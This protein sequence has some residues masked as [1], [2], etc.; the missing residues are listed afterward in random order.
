MSKSKDASVPWQATG[1]KPTMFESI[2]ETFDS[3]AIAFI[4]AFLFRSFE[5]EAFVIPTGSMALTLMGAHKEI[6]CPQCSMPYRVG[7]SE[8]FPEEEN[9]RP[10]RV[11][12][13]ICPNCR[14]RDVYADHPDTFPPTF[15]GDRILVTKFP[16]EFADPKRFDVA[17][18]KNPGE[19]KQNYI[20]RVVGLPQ[21][22]IL[23]YRGDI[24]ARSPEANQF[25][26]ARK[27]PEKIVAIM[28]TVYDNDH[29]L[30]QLIE[31]GWPQRWRQSQ[32]NGE[33]VA[34][35]DATWQTSADM[36][37]FRAVGK[38]PVEAWLRYEHV[39]PDDRAWRILTQRPLTDEDRRTFCKPQL[40]AD[41]CEYNT[42]E[43]ND[44]SALGIHWVSDLAL[45]CELEFTDRADDN[46]EAILEL[47]EGG[48]A[49]QCRIRAATGDVEL[50]IEGVEGYHPTAKAAVVGK[51]PHRLRFA[52]ID[53]HLLLWVGN[54]PIAFDAST[55]FLATNS[56]PVFTIGRDDNNT[57]RMVTQGHK[58]DGD[59]KFPPLEI[60]IPTE[61][62]LRSPVG[63]AA[64][65]VDITASHL[66]LK[67]DLYYVADKG[68]EHLAEYPT[69]PPIRDNVADYRDNAFQAFE[70]PGLTQL[71][72]EWRDADVLRAFM[73]DVKTAPERWS[74]LGAVTF[75]LQADQFFVLGDN[76]PKS[77]DGRLW[78]GQ[79]YESYVKRELLIGKAL[80]VYWPHGFENVPGTSIGLP[81]L[82]FL[83]NQYGPNFR[84]MRLIR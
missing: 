41:F 53:D 82:P 62:D 51:G 68:R 15:N 33:A 19:A 13:S 10:R 74:Q 5:A 47:V 14:F 73:S 18:F 54:K 65:G 36:K 50:R 49:F 58:L 2:R 24:Y 7:A 43:A 27:S 38:S 42:G 1:P 83:G 46:A 57:P 20:K 21:E 59:T 66:H 9:K 37:S 40:I 70:H 45:E 52:N 64:R 35:K 72:S 56:A 69:W 28:Q 76:S 79:G 67:R 71:S 75:Q 84:A 80:F 60:G 22:E 44:I 77:L 34:A 17:V 48:K 8:E 32:P 61:Q 23:I 78:N 31:R 12:S 4:L 81:D 6:E 63:I 25:T 30:P 11:T 16:Y 39:V 55:N 26:I 29:V 3:I